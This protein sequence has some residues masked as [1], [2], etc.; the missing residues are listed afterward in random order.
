MRST[1]E[2]P[3]KS[4]L[5]RTAAYFSMRLPGAKRKA[6]S[7]GS[8]EE[9][10]QM[11][12]KQPPKPKTVASPGPST[13]LAAKDGPQGECQQTTHFTSETKHTI[14]SLPDS[15]TLTV[16]SSQTSKLT[17]LS[18]PQSRAES[19]NNSI[20]SE[21]SVSQS[22][23]RPPSSNKVTNNEPSSDAR[24]SDVTGETLPVPA[25]RNNGSGG[26]G[27]VRHTYQNIPLPTKD[28]S[29]GVQPPPLQ[30]PPQP[31]PSVPE[32]CLVF[33]FI[34]ILCSDLCSSWKMTITAFLES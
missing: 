11:V 18:R 24:T 5:A 9:S 22:F 26:G 12:Q 34:I 10:H 27:R 16:E 19:N 6:K 1:N 8:N 33:F 28:K 31:Y 13:P 20:Y 3:T 30:Q 7:K 29:M 21:G 17:V 25:P 32:V 14:T 4:A 15:N 23:P 2:K